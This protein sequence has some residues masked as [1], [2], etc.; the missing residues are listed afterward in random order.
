MFLNNITNVRIIP[1]YEIEIPLTFV[2]FKNSA[3]YKL[4]LRSFV[5]LSFFTVPALYRCIFG[6]LLFDIRA[7]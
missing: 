1:V 5:P 2:E 3:G 6:V 7:I 4:L